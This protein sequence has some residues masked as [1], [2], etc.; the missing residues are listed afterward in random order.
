MKIER[1]IGVA[2][3]TKE[4]YKRLLE[5]SDDRSTMNDT[6][7]EWNK[8]KEE[9]KKNFRSLGIKVKDVK[10]DL[11]QLIR[12]C[13]LYGLPNNSK[14]RAQFVQEKMSGTIE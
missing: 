2:I 5:I 6:W 4:D 14:T 1:D 13:Q 3:Y 10:I 9:M 12:Y 8:K 7:A 11:E